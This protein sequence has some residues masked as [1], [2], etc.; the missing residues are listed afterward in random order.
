MHSFCYEQPWIEL[1]E[2]YVNPSQRSRG[3]GSALCLK[4][5]HVAEELGAAQLWLRTNRDNEQAHRVYRRAG[6]E[7]T[8][9]I[10]CRR[11]LTADIP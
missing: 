7:A 4:A 6:F 10:V 1:T 5:V 8:D 9:E 2:F 11:V 3:I